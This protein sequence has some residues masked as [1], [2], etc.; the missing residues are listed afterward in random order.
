MLNMH[1]VSH[2][3][4][5]TQA[6]APILVEVTVENEV[7]IIPADSLEYNGTHYVIRLSSIFVWDEDIDGNTE[8]TLE[9]DYGITRIT[10]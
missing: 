7:F 1:H 2:L 3:H 10:E 6:D 5:L 8:L 4:N 9:P